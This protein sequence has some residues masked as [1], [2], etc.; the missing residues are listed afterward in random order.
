M[1]EQE[2]IW[3]AVVAWMSAKGIQLAKRLPWMPITFETETL[4][5]WMARAV[6]LVATFGLHATFDASAGVLTIT[7]L[8]WSGVFLSI[9]DYAKQF[10]LQEIAYKKFIR[11]EGA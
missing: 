11:A 8:T 10:M 4:N 9:G 2:L 3:S 1:S 5:R 7:G 6:A